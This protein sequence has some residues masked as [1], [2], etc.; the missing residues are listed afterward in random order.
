MLY[1][2]SGMMM[3]KWLVGGSVGRL[4]GLQDRADFS[5]CPLLAGPLARIVQPTSELNSELAGLPASGQ[6]LPTF[7][8]AILID[9]LDGR[10]NECVSGVGVG[11]YIAASDA[12]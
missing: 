9:C 6:R 11:V 12:I 1:V 4:V 5:T 7:H 2:A 3:C 10:R 8:Y